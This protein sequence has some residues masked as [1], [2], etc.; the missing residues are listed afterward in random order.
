V[1]SVIALR[2]AGSVVLL[3]GL[4][5]QASDDRIVW[6]VQPGFRDVGAIRVADG[7]VFTGN[8]TGRGGT[9]ALDA[10]TGKGLW[11][12][13]GQQRGAPIPSGRMVFTANHQMG[14]SALDS[15]TGKPVW[16]APDFQPAQRT[17]LLFDGTGVYAVGF[18]GK[19][20]A[21]DAATGAL[22]W[23]HIHKPGGVN[24]GCLSTPIAAD[25]LIIYSGGM[26][27]LTGLVWGLDPA[28]GREVWRSPA[29]CPGYTTAADGIVAMATHAHLT[30]LDA[31]TGRVLWQ[32]AP[33]EEQVG[34]RTYQRALSPPVI[35]DGRV[36]AIHE[37]GLTGWSLRTGEKQFDFAGNFPNADLPSH[38]EIV[39]GTAY[40]VANF[41]QPAAE[42]NRRGFLYG[43]DLATRQVVFRHRVN[44]DKPYVE[45]WGT[46]R[47]R[48]DGAFIYYEN[49]SILV[50]VRR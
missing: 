37:N 31:S 47:F 50:K 7:L 32:T 6:E 2:D 12:T 44:R 28:T 21:V 10:A 36:Y 22:R 38:L 14:I 17:D 3:A 46:H 24:G 4:L 11:R 9:V 15:K 41:E 23:E 49:E 25:G 19:L 29:G 5:V 13:G 18:E 35:A 42:G 39:D 20:W 30:G 8:I 26:E 34:E 27:D 45:T 43:L 1:R 48:V 33:V 40:F 16:R